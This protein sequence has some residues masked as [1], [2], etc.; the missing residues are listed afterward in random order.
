MSLLKRQNFDPWAVRNN[1][2][3]INGLVGSQQYQQL[4]EQL[5]RM[6]ADSDGFMS[7]IAAAARE[8]ASAC[9]V[10]HANAEWYRQNVVRETAQEQTLLQT[11]GALCKLAEDYAV[12]WDANKGRGNGASSGSLLAGSDQH[13]AAPPDLARL[14]PVPSLWQRIQDVWTRAI[15]PPPV[16]ASEVEELVKGNGARAPG[17]QPPTPHLPDEAQSP[18]LAVYCLGKF[19]VYLDNHPLNNWPGRKSKQ[20]FKYLILHHSTPTPK[21]VLMDLC[22]PD[23]DPD[24]AR[25]NLNVTI[26]GLRQMLRAGNSSFSYI[27]FQDDCYFF[28]PALRMWIDVDLFMEYSE[29]ARP[30]AGNG[31]SDVSVQDCLAAETLY[32][33]ELFEEDRYENWIMPQRHFLQ[34]LYLGLLQ[35]LSDHYFSQNNFAMTA[36]ICNKVL[37]VDTCHEAAHQ[38]LMICYTRQGQRQLALRQYHLC[39]ETLQRELDIPPS[40]ATEKLYADILEDAALPT[41]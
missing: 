30:L 14:A 34:I 27:L 5:D 17:V 25:N 12:S 7:E 13:A 37:A 20:V 23:T 11:L 15:Q 8:I 32:Q 31:V 36:A 6:A 10:S 18:A 29:K 33:G 21:E 9:D 26:Y 35:R 38:R 16:P 40:A 2:R 4:Q 28:N 24:A 22:W 3:T 39:V 41:P 19:R 1:W